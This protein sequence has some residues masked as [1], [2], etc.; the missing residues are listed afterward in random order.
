[1]DACGWNWIFRT[2]SAETVCLRGDLGYRDTNAYTSGKV[3]L[4]E[5]LINRWMM[6]YY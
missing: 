3:L 2:T 5:D 1:M 4:N 6:I